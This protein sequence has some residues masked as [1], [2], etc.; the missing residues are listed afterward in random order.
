MTI[1]EYWRRRD[2][3]RVAS[4]GVS[5]SVKA[6]VRNRSKRVMREV[7]RSCGFPVAGYDIILFATPWHEGYLAAGVMDLTLRVRL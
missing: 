3:G 6:G 7:A 5:D 1:C 4:V 2:S